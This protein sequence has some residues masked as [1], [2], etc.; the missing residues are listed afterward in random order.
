MSEVPRNQEIKFDG[1]ELSNQSTSPKEGWP[2]PKRVI[3]RMHETSRRLVFFFTKEATSL[4]GKRT[5]GSQTLMESW[6]QF[7]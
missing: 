3:P 4:D 1:S 5:P 2:I 6:C 7:V